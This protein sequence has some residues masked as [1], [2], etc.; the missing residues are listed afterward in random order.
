M[1]HFLAIL[2][3]RESESRKDGR[4][5]RFI[6]PPCRPDAPAESART[7]IVLTQSISNHYNALCG[8]LTEGTVSSL[9]CFLKAFTR[10]ADMEIPV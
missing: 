9:G 1:M 10:F 6:N 7:V 5:S 3:V 8:G 2:P 4:D